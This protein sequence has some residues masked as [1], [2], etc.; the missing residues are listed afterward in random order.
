EIARE[1]VAKRRPRGRGTRPGPLDHLPSEYE[2][3]ALAQHASSARIEI[4]EHPRGVD[5]E[6]VEYATG[7]RRC[8]SRVRERIRER[9][10][11]RLPPPARALVLTDEGLDQDLRGGCDPAPAGD[12]D[13]GADRVAL[14]RHGRRASLACGLAH[15]ADLRL[16]EQRHVV[17]DLR[18]R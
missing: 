3:R 18:A 1:L 2:R 8:T 10:P 6:P 5:M 16:L 11:F 4:R 7:R 12:R 15:L 13:R 14:V 17:A 9:A